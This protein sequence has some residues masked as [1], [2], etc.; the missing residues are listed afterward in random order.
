M[1]FRD[2]VNGYRVEE[3][4]KLLREDQQLTVLAIA[5]RVGFNTNDA[6]Y[7]AFKKHSDATPAAYRK[8][9]ES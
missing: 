3:A 6:F 8:N 5:H 7:R 4:K 2:V 9:H 1:S